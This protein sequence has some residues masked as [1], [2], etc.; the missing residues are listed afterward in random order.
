MRYVLFIIALCSLL[1]SG[2]G[3]LIHEKQL[4]DAMLGAKDLR[5]YDARV[6]EIQH[7]RCKGNCYRLIVS[8][9]VSGKRQLSKYGGGQMLVGQTLI[10]WAKP[11][12]EYAYISPQAYVSSLA[13]SWSPTSL[14]LLPLL[15]LLGAVAST[16]LSAWRN[17]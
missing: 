10:V 15:A 8:Y 11:N 2:I 13:P 4:S 7:Y 6:E 1:I 17:S 14:L 5:P 12:F 16:K 3:Y 9:V